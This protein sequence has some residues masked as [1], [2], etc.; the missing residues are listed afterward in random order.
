M[1]M[2]MKIQRNKKAKNKKLILEE[3]EI[4][5]MRICLNSTVSKNV[6]EKE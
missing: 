6:L 2:N 5:I 1:I 3:F 4:T